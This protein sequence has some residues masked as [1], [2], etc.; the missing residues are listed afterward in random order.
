MKLCSISPASYRITRY[1]EEEVWRSYQR[2]QEFL[3]FIPHCDQQTLHFLAQ[4]VS[5][6]GRVEWRSDFLHS[7]CPMSEL[8]PEAKA[9]CE[10]LVKQ[11]IQQL[12]AIAQRNPD[13]AGLLSA[14]LDIASQ[15]DIY[16][17]ENLHRV[18]VANW[19]ARHKGMSNSSAYSFNVAQTAPNIPTAT[20]SRE[21]PQSQESPETVETSPEP[22]PTQTPGIVEPIPEPVAPAE[23]VPPSPSEMPSDSAEPSPSAEYISERTA[24]APT[25]ESEPIVAQEDSPITASPVTPPQTPQSPPPPPSQP[26]ATTGQEQSIPA[27]SAPEKQEDSQP[28]KGLWGRL[29]KVLGYL[30]G[31]L[32]L[33]LLLALALSQCDGDRGI[34]DQPGHCIPINPED[35]RYDSDSICQIVGNR[36]NI[37]IE[38]KG[39]VDEFMES[40]LN[41]YPDYSILYYDTVVQRVQVQVPEE[42]REQFKQ[43]LPS[44]MQGFK[45]IAWDEA[46][47][48]H[49]GIPNDPGFT[50]EEEAWYFPCV[51]AYGAWDREMGSDSLIVAIIDN[52]FDLSHPE[53]KDRVIDQ[54]NVLTRE[55]RV[56]SDKANP[57][58]THVAA[59]AVGAANNSAGVSGIAPRCRLMAIQVADEAGQMSTTSVMDGVIY[60]ILHGAKVINLSLG[61]NMVSMKAFSEADQVNIMN[62]FGIEEAKVWDKIYAMAEQYGATV[63]L[64]GGNDSVLIGLDP[65][66]RSSRAIKVSAID[67]ELAVADFSNYGHMSTISAPG[68]KIYNAFPN[69]QYEAINGTSMAAPIV[70]GGIALIKSKYPQL[71][72]GQIAELI[73]HTGQPL[74]GNVGPLIQL[75]KALSVGDAGGDMGKIPDPNMGLPIDETLPP[76]APNFPGGPVYRDPDIPAPEGDPLAPY[77]PKP[78]QPDDS[79]GDPS[80][81][82]PVIPPRPK[83]PGTPC[84]D[85][86]RKID[87]LRRVIRDLEDICRSEATQ[88]MMRLNERTTLADLSG[89]WRSTTDLYASIDDEPVE[90]YFQIK[91]DGTGTVTYQETSTGHNF[92]APLSV[93]LTQSKLQLQQQGAAR[94]S[95]YPKESYNQHSF[96][97]EADV[98]GGVARCYATSPQHT[99]VK[100]VKFNMILVSK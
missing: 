77:Y 29:K 99:R 96:Y 10:Q 14:S 67:S 90:L 26:E 75:D 89:H 81:T 48:A 47:F 59:T 87:S 38:E 41:T 24:V 7:A 55:H 86:K 39:R 45:L 68:V 1:R 33:F 44:R 63:V 18:A 12:Q 22:Q 8:A 6:A 20:A 13:W 42:Q 80:T 78:G 9:R 58:G 74:E 36:V 64:A 72:T 56:Y 52:G 53:L 17:D 98:S 34:P 25:P 50:D 85:A 57:H 62:S 27:A 15:E 37:Y 19:G 43:E 54:Y 97:A 88:D 84:H 61:A 79:V 70:T 82:L 40:F 69:A 71:S 76:T 16:Y 91:P 30:L 46:M 23:S 95:Q 2:I 49:D 5:K 35:I 66:Q 32:F 51:R 92:R 21:M 28:K 73:R 83:A 100:L 31:L 93:K 60:A 11:T 3:K 4:P 65:M 94:N